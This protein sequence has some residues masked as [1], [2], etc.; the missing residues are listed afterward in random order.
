MRRL[1][2]SLS[3]LA[4]LALVDAASA[5][6]APSQPLSL[7]A[8]SPTNLRPAL[9]WAVPASVGAGIAGYNVYRGATK[10]TTSVISATTYTDTTV[11]ANT[12][13]SYTVVAVE[14]GTLATSPPS[15]A[16]S[17]AY[18][19][20]P[21]PAPTAAAAAT[22]TNAAVV[23]TWTAGAAD[24]FS[25]FRR[26]DIYRGTTLIGS[27][28]A[29][30][31]TDATL[32]SAGSNTYGIKAED[33]AGNLSG[34]ST[35]TVVF[36]N[37]APATPAGFAPSGAQRT[38][39]TLSWTAAVDTGGA[40]IGHYEV[41]L[42]PAS[43]PLVDIGGTTATSFVDAAITTEGT[44]AFQ[45]VAVDNAGNVSPPTAVRPVQ[46]DVT[47]PSV[48][49]TLTAGPSPTAAKPIFAFGTALDTGGSG[50][51]LYRL[52]RNGTGVASSASATV[53]DSTVATD[54]S[55][56]YY[57]TAV[58]AAGNESA[59]SNQVTV[60]YDKTAP[61]APTGLTAGPSPT[62][63]APTLSWSSGGPDNLSGFARYDIYRG[64]ALAGSTTGLSF[65]D[66]SLASSGPQSY[67]VKAV[68][69]A[70]NVSAAS[71]VRS[72]TYDVLAPPAPATVTA[73]VATRL[74]PTIT[75]TTSTDPGGSGIARY[76]IYRDGA[77]AGTATAL[78]FTEP[79]PTFADG[80]YTYTVS[81]VDNAGNEGP[82]TAPKVV[83]YDTAAPLAPGDPTSAPA[84]TKNPP[85]ATWTAASDV[86]GSGIATYTVYRDGG[87]VGSV[88]GLSY[89]EPASFRTSG[90]YKYTVRAVDVAGN[91]SALTA[92]ASVVYDT[93][94]PPV[95][96]GLTGPSPTGVKPVLSWTSGGPD[97]LS[98]L[99]HYE[100]YRGVTLVGSTTA[101]TFSDLLAPSATSSYTVKAVD[102]AGNVSAASVPRSIVYDTTPPPAPS[103][104]K[105]TSPTALPV[106]SW[107]A[108]VDTSG[109]NQYFIYRDGAAIAVG[110]TTAKTWTDTP[111]PAEGTHSYAVAA[112]DN[113][114][115][116]GVQ[117]S[118]INVVVDTT[119]PPVPTSLTGASPTRGKPLLVWTSGGADVGSGFAHYDVF[120][121]GAPLGS[122]LATAYTDS[123]LTTNDIY[124]YTVTAV[125]VAGNTSAPTAGIQVAWD[126][127][128]PP[129]PSGLTAATPVTG[130]PHLTWLSS[131]PDGL[132]G[133]DH[134]DVY[135]GSTL[136]G[137]PTMPV[138]DDGALLVD[139]TFS[140]S[141]KS[142]DVAGN[143]SVASIPRI[144]VR[145][146]TP[147][148]PP[149]IL[150]AATP[151]RV[152]PA[153]SWSAPSD[154]TGSGVAS[155]TVL[156]DGVPIFTTGALAYIDDAALVDG[157]YAYA[158]VAT[159]GAGNGSGPS[160]AASIRLDTAAPPAPSGLAGPTPTSQPSLAWTQTTDALTGGSGIASYR[161]YRNTVF[162]GTSA[163]ATFIDVA[164]ALDDV[165]DYTVT[166]VDGAGNESA[167]GSIATVMFDHTPPSRPVGLLAVTTSQAKPSLSWSSG[168]PD[169]LSGFAHYN[170]YRD[171]GLIGSP[172]VP[173]FVDAALPVNGS[174][175]YIV[176]AV[177]AAGNLSLP[178]PALAVVW[179]T[180]APDV[181]GSVV[182]ST[183][184]IQPVLSWTPSGDMGGAGIARY[185]VYR[186]AAP[187]ASTTNATYQDGDVLAV[188]GVHVYAVQ[189]VDGAGN[190][191]ALS[192][193]VNASIDRTAPAVPA[194][195][196]AASPT[197]RPV[198][199]WT[200]SADLGAAPVGVA[201]YDVFRGGV[202]I[203]STS[204][205]TYQDDAITTEGTAY[206]TVTAI[207]RAGNVSVPSL[208]VPVLFDVTP[209]P[210]PSHVQSTTPTADLPVITWTPSGNDNLS[211]LDHYDVYR[212]D[213]LVSSPVLPSFV[214]AAL[215]VQGVHTYAVRAVDV[216]GNRSPLSPHVTVVYDTTPPMTPTGLFV[217]SPT[218]LPHLV[219]DAAVDD[220]T[221]A[222]GLDHYNV[223]RDSSVVGHAT[224]TSFDDATV[225]GD[226]SYG[227]TVTAVDRAGNESLASRVFVVRVDLTPPPAPGDLT[228]ATPTHTPI[229]SWSAGTDAGT[230]GSAITGYRVYRD[231]ALLGDTLGT[232]YTDVNPGS[233]GHRIYTVRAIDSAGN[234]GA[235]T[236][237]LDVI[238]DLDGPTLTNVT[239]PATAYVGRVVTFSVV[240][241]DVL[242]SVDGQASWDLGDGYLLGNGI[243]HTYQAP[244]TYPVTVKVKD[245]LG[246]VTVLIGRSITV[247]IPPGGVPPKI[248]K[249]DLIRKMS[250]SAVSSNGRQFSYRVY[251]DVR[252]QIEVIL[253]R[254]GAV[255]LDRVRI[256]PAGAS[257]GVIRIPKVEFRRDGYSI[258]IL[259]TNAN[260]SARRTFRIV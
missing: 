16:L 124:T 233:S 107:V 163:T 204:A 76:N 224:T 52:Y 202:L 118:A 9:S 197:A 56:A 205:T 47:A 111:A 214:D 212:D 116:A 256:V 66:S 8:A 23:L 153:L 240:P 193:S 220:D 80:S 216:A 186:D 231:G 170:V 221:G 59:P 1:L 95:P 180:T 2:G 250:F 32:V 96:T 88:T 187:I 149:V 165:Y 147:P 260:L 24:A 55:Y 87:L 40:G 257:R 239:L 144:V 246:N 219:W 27:T 132:S 120:R 210:I 207:D 253:F 148:A 175:V 103:G 184:S 36:D 167:R 113:A 242:S 215:G 244:G 34:A 158:V 140:Y 139:G 258:Q 38:K 211:G 238:V 33:W 37:V 182:V 51:T 93:L 178:T 41:Y 12:T 50:V 255:I 183:P 168:V 14:V 130:S 235:P 28:P 30:T 218:N 192:D 259:A 75:W 26:F 65:T 159:D 54:G 85:A 68:D 134:Y 245:I 252:T 162:I 22:P 15:A 171:G 190:A 150:T 117:T 199:R 21:P 203:G 31:F 13:S 191:S 131:G 201:R 108:P 161:L 249:V 94:A 48:P 20:A 155:Y 6:A 42:V 121:N 247:T 243:A 60:V 179:D 241:V 86:G 4:I 72:I 57:V 251:S 217:A 129:A 208:G 156:R 44:Y 90:T 29:A 143:A 105:A 101:T 73:P 128:P 98:G 160:L 119:P 10:L 69:I 125:D 198:L 157:V 109:I 222:S 172:T 11:G 67:T 58:D 225:P 110:S 137:S 39:P 5:L 43:G 79:T 7:T 152:Q 173:T 77:L 115:N 89:Q 71:A 189:A 236:A 229:L 248:L 145:D 164:V 213:V 45:V 127:A 169:A 254:H 64:A 230:G 114:G 74:K 122:S 63:S 166:A 237:P 176:R 226:G 84:V 177:D 106:L 91:T 19:T 228:A 200:A 104:L 206:Y 133:F 123:T 97:A 126:N 188:E 82:Q 196:A 102:L 209:P 18:D 195:V 53:T 92:P 17:V 135:R 194:G 83:T 62:S 81:A 223:Y 35:K 112:V 185:V 49:G 232:T 154:G 3:L 99:D 100:L 181:P 234:S 46:Y 78:T 141:V 136:V 151:T 138:F 227:Y 142:V 61:P 25:G 70:G 146:T 174:F